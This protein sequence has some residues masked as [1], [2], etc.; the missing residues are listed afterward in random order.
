MNAGSDSAGT[1]ATYP[2]D[3]QAHPV[4]ASLIAN[5]TIM[6]LMAGKVASGVKTLDVAQFPG[7][8]LGARLASCIGNLPSTGGICDAR[9]LTG[10]QSI[11]SDPFAGVM[12]PVTV[13]LRNVT[14]T[15][16]PTSGHS[17]CMSPGSN[18]KLVGSGAGQTIIQEPPGTP[19]TAYYSAITSQVGA[20]NLEVAWIEFVGAN[21]YSYK[22]RQQQH[23][24]LLS[25]AVNPYIHNNKFSG[26]WN[27][28]GT[29]AYGGGSV[30]WAPVTN[31]RV[32]NNYYTGQFR[33]NVSLDGVNGADISLNYSVATGSNFVHGEPDSCKPANCATQRDVI[34]HD[35][36]DIPAMPGNTGGISFTSGDPSEDPLYKNI[37]VINNVLIGTQGINLF[38]HTGTIVS[39]NSVIDSYARSMGGCA[40]HLTSPNS[41][42]TANVVKWVNY[43]AQNCGIGVQCHTATCT[44]SRG[45]YTVTDNI[46]TS[47]HGVGISVDSAPNTTITGGAIDGVTQKSNFSA[48][49]ALG[50]HAGDTGDDYDT[51]SGV[52]IKDSQSSPTTKYAYSIRTGSHN[53]VS[54]N[55]IT[56]VT[57]GTWYSDS[58]SHTV[59]KLSNG[60]GH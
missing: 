35:N 32:Q 37:Q 10:A 29:L 54:A 57:E 45:H 36:I 33:E 11:R 49:I 5:D 26:G 1:T 42:V 22:S 6:H 47:A 18:V 4:D 9:T 7:S 2:R 15:C 51:I 53:V 25:A 16:F 34:V 17:Y 43:T 59:P 39:G 52:T 48:A 27:G 24:I 30:K 14:I 13:W 58:Q 40:I 31:L 55:T 20:T 3:G 12:N 50:A 8:D 56:N 38:G 60:Q 44:G 46:V 28:D 23:A 21:N 19:T 41:R